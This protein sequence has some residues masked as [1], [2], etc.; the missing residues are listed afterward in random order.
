MTPSIKNVAVIGAGVIGTG[1]IIRFLFNQKKVK[2]YDPQIKQRKFL[3]NEIKR[4]EPLLSKI[5]KKKIN[6]LNS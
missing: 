6:Y 5:Y 1:W 3:L 4:V 2:V